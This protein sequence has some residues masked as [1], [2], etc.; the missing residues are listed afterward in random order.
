MAFPFQQWPTL[1]EYLAWA[2]SQGFKVVDGCVIDGPSG[3]ASKVVTITTPAPNKK[4]LIIYDMMDSE[5]LAPSTIAHF[6]RRL[7]VTSPWSPIVP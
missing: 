7:G 6:D 3:D 5:R 2:E 1:R 4:R